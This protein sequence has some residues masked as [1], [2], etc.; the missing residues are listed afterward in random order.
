MSLTAINVIQLL[1]IN[2]PKVKS[3]NNMT[4]KAYNTRIVQN[5]LDQLRLNAEFD[6]LNPL[7][8]KVIN[9]GAEF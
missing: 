6:V 8:A 2:N 9:L 7:V 1:K 5:L 4:R 3:L